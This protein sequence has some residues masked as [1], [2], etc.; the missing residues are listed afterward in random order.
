MNA[1]GTAL[2]PTV[3]KGFLDKVLPLITTLI[4]F[5]LYGALMFQLVPD[6]QIAWGLIGVIGPLVG[7][8]LRS[9]GIM[10]K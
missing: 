3:G 7:V 5:A 9:A 1:V 6:P 4:Y 8:Y 2:N 10:P